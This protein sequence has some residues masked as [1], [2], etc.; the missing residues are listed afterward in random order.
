MQK[1]ILLY[2]PFIL[3]SLG[4]ITE[5]LL[6]FFL[7]KDTSYSLMLTQLSTS[8][9]VWLFLVYF[10]T[11]ASDFLCSKKSDFVFFKLKK[12]LI[13]F[14]CLIITIFGFIY[15]M[16]WAT[17]LETNSF[18]TL[19]DIK[20]AQE[21]IN[22]GLWGHLSIAQR[23][24]TI[25]ITILYPIFIFFLC[26]VLS[27]VSSKIR[28][29][30]LRHKMKWPLI[31]SILLFSIS[32]ACSSG[33]E[34]ENIESNNEIYVLNPISVLATSIIQDAAEE[35]AIN[36]LGTILTENELTV[37][38]TKKNI[39]ENSTINKLNVI[40]IQVEAMRSDIIGKKQNGLEVTPFLNQYAKQST[41][42]TRAY[43]TSTH[44]SFAQPSVLSS[45]WP[46]RRP[47]HSKWSSDP[48][49]P[50]KL[51]YEIL[52]E[53]GYHTAVFASDTQEWQG[54]KYFMK[55]EL[56]DRFFDPTTNGGQ[57]KPDPRDKDAYEQYE[58]GLLSVGPMTDST[59]VNRAIEWLNENTETK[60][61]FY[62]YLNLY[63]SHF[64]YALSDQTHKIFL[65]SD[66]PTN[67]SYGDY[68]RSLI[69]IAKNSYY[70]S[71]HSIDQL[72]KEFFEKLEKMKL[73]KNTIVVVF[74]DHGESFGENDQLCHGFLPVESQSR[75]T[76]LIHGPKH[77]VQ[78]TEDDYPASLIDVV[79]SVL[80]IL[81]FPKYEILQGV[82]L[83]SKVRVPKEQRAIFTYTAAHDRA[84]AIILGGRWKLIED[85]YRQNELLYDLKNDPDETINLIDNPAQKS[86]RSQLRG[87]LWLWYNQQIAY[88]VNPK[89]FEKYNPPQAPK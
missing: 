52:K 69:P 53:N 47:G 18:L 68:P 30:A 12:T 15:I 32:Y 29:K 10:S 82:N 75:I 41:L 27:S 84:A 78:P 1:N 7:D 51:V 35:S 11:F 19:A 44:T 23:S 42:F 73:A 45:L 6:H 25:V 2:I 21:N 77:L 62:L 57:A 13:L 24:H 79:P 74:G 83:F 61:P 36:N 37:L 85:L 8:L 43:S 88:Y 81:G 70:N 66:L 31:F 67:A 14:A 4:F 17:R 64:P 26:V 76:L 58:K 5:S 3:G 56:L 48:K 71:L 28:F 46:L 87:Q 49:W 54:L 22:K 86:V 9:L 72:L 34:I 39:F 60:K 89:F 33:S 55:P 40:F 50:K 16:S 20:L 63:R 38:D 59:T 65:P 80:G